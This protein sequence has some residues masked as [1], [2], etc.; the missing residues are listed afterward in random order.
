MSDPLDEFVYSTIQYTTADTAEYFRLQS[1]IDTITIWNV[2]QCTC[3]LTLRRAVGTIVVM[4]R[5]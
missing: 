5:Q 1:T 4:E 2:T 3:N